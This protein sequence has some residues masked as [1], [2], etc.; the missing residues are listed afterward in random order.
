MRHDEVR[1]VTAH[2]FKEMCHDVTAEPMPLLLQGGQLPRRTANTSN[3]T[4]VDVS[5]RGYWTRGQKDYF[6]IR[7]FDPIARCQRSV[8]QRRPQ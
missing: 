5:A 6:D 3:D 2:T 8:F 1:D 4:R 7:I